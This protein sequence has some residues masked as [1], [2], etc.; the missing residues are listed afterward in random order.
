MN[1]QRRV[2]CLRRAGVRSWPSSS[3]CCCCSPRC[4]LPRRV[5][6]TSV[7]SSASLSAASSWRASASSCS[8]SDGR[9][10]AR[11]LALLLLL[12]L[13]RLGRIFVAGAKELTFGV[14]DLVQL[15]ARVEEMLERDR[16]FRGGD[17]VDVLLLGATVD[18]K[19]V[20][21]R[22]EREERERRASPDPVGELLGI[23]HCRR[24]QNDV[25]VVG[26][27]DDDLLPHDTTLEVID[28]VHLVEDDPLD[29]AYEIGSLRKKRDSG[30]DL[31]KSLCKMLH[32]L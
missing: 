15:L 28:V 32:T 12:A 14:D 4:D 10:D 13:D 9:Q 2:P 26:K 5:P 27:H 29:V 20:S 25:D 23:R 3:C 18:K 19:S 30:S 21:K 11:R 6:T 31:S 8:S 16:S 22:G 1:P 24:E 7:L 17:D